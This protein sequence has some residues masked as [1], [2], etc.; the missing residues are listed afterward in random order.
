M[1]RRNRF[2]VSPRDF[3]RILNSLGENQQFILAVPLQEQMDADIHLL[4]QR[5]MQREDFPA[6]RRPC[7]H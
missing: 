6:E 2:R 4:V 7:L 1:L 3:R 5:L